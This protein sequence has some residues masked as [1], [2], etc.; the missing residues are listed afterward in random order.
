MPIDEACKTGTCVTIWNYPKF[1]SP[2]LCKREMG[3]FATQSTGLRIHPLVTSS[4]RR[5]PR[6]PELQRTAAY[7][8]LNDIAGQELTL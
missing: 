3:G 5:L 6:L 2:P 1:P 7:V 8:D 4:S